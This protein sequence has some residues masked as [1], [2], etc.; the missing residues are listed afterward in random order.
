LCPSS[1]EE[2]RRRPPPTRSGA[3]RRRHVGACARCGDDGRGGGGEGRGGK[4][5]GSSKE[6]DHDRGEARR[7]FGTPPP[8]RWTSSAARSGTKVF[9]AFVAA[10]LFRK[11]AAFPLAFS[12]EGAFEFGEGAHDRDLQKRRISHGTLVSRSYFHPRCLNADNGCFVDFD[13][14]DLDVAQV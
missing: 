12:D 3:C 9:A 13:E 14:P 2:Q 5:L 11:G 8:A 6:D 10:A 7:P 4:D 1:G